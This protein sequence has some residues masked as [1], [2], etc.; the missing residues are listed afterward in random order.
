MSDDLSIDPEITLMLQHM[1][2]THHGIPE[3]GSPKPPMIIEAEIL[4][5]LDLMDA[6]IYDFT[7]SLQ[8]VEPGEFSE[9]VWSMDKRRL[10]KHKI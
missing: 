9:P 6:R 4:H 1:I 2:L 3:Y 5:L 8:N 10:Y 7:E